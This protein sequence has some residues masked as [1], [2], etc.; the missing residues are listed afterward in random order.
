MPKADAAGAPSVHTEIELKLAIAPQDL[1]RLAKAP[2]LKAMQSG[3]ARTRSLNATYFDTPDNHFQRHG[4]HFRIRKEDG[5]FV[6]TVKAKG[7]SGGSAFGR[8]EWALPVAQGSPD[9]G[10]LGADDVLGRLMPAAGA[11]KAVFETRVQRTTRR[12]KPASGGEISWDL[13]VGEIVT[14]AGSSPLHELELELVSGD[15]SQLFRVAR[16]VLNVVPARLIRQSKADRGY[17]LVVGAGPTYHK[18]RPHRW[19]ADATT[20][21]VL[22]AVVTGCLDQLVAN[23]DCVLQRAHIEGVHQMR[24]A[25]RRLRAVFDLHRDLIPAAQHAALAGHVKRI[26]AVLGPARDWDVMVHEVIRPVIAAEREA[27]GAELARLNQAATAARERAYGA[28][29]AL[30]HSAAYGAA[31]LDLGAW[32]ESREWRRPATGTA[33]A[34]LASPA[35][36]LAAEALAKR[37][38]WLAKRGS[39]LADLAPAARHRVRLAVKK[40]RY[41]AEILGSL[42]GPR[43]AKRYTTRLVALQDVLGHLN[44]VAMARGRLAELVAGAESDTGLAY[45]AGLVIGW[46]EHNRILR[47]AALRAT[48]NRFA[49][50][51]PFWT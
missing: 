48:W 38:R 20:E 25:L 32:V 42:F 46:H 19:D 49:K 36:T 41:A 43:A 17:A 1:G 31:V 30:L 11:L 5:R 33:A 50:A 2:W 21:R 14:E 29:R 34:G 45:G 18:A 35:R 16:Q 12:L 24:V 40:Q 3:R 44:D 26:N 7:A 27:D 28:V 8:R 51:D 47:E 37:H 22:A 39:R 6:Q 13:D 10:P 9:T 23:E 4:L 15:P